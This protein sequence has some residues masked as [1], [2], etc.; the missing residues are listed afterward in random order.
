MILALASVLAP[1]LAAAAGFVVLEDEC[2]GR[3]LMIRGEIEPGD[4][5]RFADAFAGLVRDDL[6][7]A[8]NPELL[9]TL[10]L[11]SPGGDLAEAMAIGR[12]VRRALVTTEVSYRFEPRA[13]G[14]W[15]FAHAADT[16]CVEGDDRLAGC[17]AK[18]AV[19]ECTGA[20]LLIWL[21]G[22][23]RRAIEGALGHHGLT[24]EAS[25]IWAYLSSMDVSPEWGARILNAPDPV[26]APDGTPPAGGD[27][28]FG[29]ADKA[30][31]SGPTPALR[32]LLAGCPAPLTPDEAIASVM[33]PSPSTRDTLLDRAEDHWRCRNARV[34]AA[35]RLAD[36]APNVAAIRN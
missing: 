26:R 21:A 36:W 17:Q 20:C 3:Q 33:T 25:E 16:L 14:V 4:A 12:I 13:D 11:D 35:R 18:I 27:G 10:K 24:A 34:D 23:D 29:W 19:A 30:A 28:W 1:V 2:N 31:L 22:A 15:D 6:P 7:P 5:Q 9:W 8:Q 32:A